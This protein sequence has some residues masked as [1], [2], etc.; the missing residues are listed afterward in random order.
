VVDHSSI[1]RWAIRFLPLLEKAFRKHKHAVGISWRTNETYI[2]VNGTW[3]YPYRA[4]D[5]QGQTVDF[6]FTAKSVM[7][8]PPAAS[9]GRLYGTM[10]CPTR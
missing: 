7:Q 4:V 9:S 10:V 8:P 6:L 3:K 5:R 2:K 1:S